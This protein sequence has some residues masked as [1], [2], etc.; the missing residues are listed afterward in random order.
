VPAAAG[1]FVPRLDAPV[2]GQGTYEHP[3]ALGVAF[4]DE[5]AEVIAWL[6]P[7]ARRRAGVPASPCE[8]AR[9]RRRGDG[10]RARGPR[11]A[12]LLDGLPLWLDPAARTP[13]VLQALAPEWIA[14]GDGASPLAIA[15]ARL[16]GWIE[17]APLASPQ[18]AQPSDPDRPSR[19]SPAQLDAW[20]DGR[21]SRGAVRRPALERPHD[22][23]TR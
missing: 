16:P 7:A 21:R 11:L 23:G 12:A 10:G 15:A 17:G 9:G 20:T 1:G 22:S 3:W 14:T 19:S 2:T 4:G 13:M 6:D 8:V 18:D 5:R